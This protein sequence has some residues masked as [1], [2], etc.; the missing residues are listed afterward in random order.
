[1][2]KF[3]PI[4]MIKRINP[5]AANRS[6]ISVVHIL[7]PIRH[8]DRFLHILVSHIPMVFKDMWRHG[9]F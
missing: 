9:I 2:K 8:N 4:K 1:M 3:C 5:F 6:G 7:Q